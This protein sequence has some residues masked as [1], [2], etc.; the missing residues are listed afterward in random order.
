M[1]CIGKENIM[2]ETVAK[3]F[4]SGLSKE[5]LE[6]T[7][8]ETKSLQLPREI[9]S[10][11][12]DFNPPWKDGPPMVMRDPLPITD[13]PPPWRSRPE[14]VEYPWKDGPEPSL[15]HKDTTPLTDDDRKK[16]KE[17]TGWPDKIISAIGSQEESEIYKSTGLV[18]AE[19][20]GRDCLIRPDID[21]NQKDEYGRTNKERME[22]GLSPLDKNGK[23]IELHHIGQKADGPLAEL[24]QEEHR[25]KGNDRI[26]HDKNKDSEIDRV[27]FQKEKEQHWE[28]RGK[29][30]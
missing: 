16:M 15:A 6:K 26:L 1:G 25:G 8:E 20:N 17:E 3:I 18:P 19:I 12:P 28:E 5:T 10:P 29:Q 2:L 22:Y 30:S 11:G 9:S 23:S 27:A 7:A 24:T 21:M 4:E 14:P 13:G